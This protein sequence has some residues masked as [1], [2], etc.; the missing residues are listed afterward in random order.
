M[1]FESTKVAHSLT[2]ILPGLIAL[3]MEKEKGLEPALKGMVRISRTTVL[4]QRPSVGHMVRI[5]QHQLDTGHMKPH[6]TTLPSA[7]MP[8]GPLTRYALRPKNEH[9]M[10]RLTVFREY[11]DS[12]EPILTPAALLRKTSPASTTHHLV[13]LLPQRRINHLSRIFSTHARM[14]MATERPECLIRLPPRRCVR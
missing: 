1:S 8:L 6:A 10:Q 2:R 14:P 11:R 13:T 9:N 7:A 12:I 5:Y 3:F 4:D